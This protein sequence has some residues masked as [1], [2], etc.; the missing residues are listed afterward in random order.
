MLTG[1]AGKSG[2]LYLV[3]TPIGNLEDLTFRALRVLKEADVIAAE[4]TRETHKL[5]AHYDIHKP[6]LSY[7]EQN[8]SIAGPRILALLGEGKTVALV[9]DAGM[10]GISDPGTDLVDRCLDAGIRVVPVPGPSAVTAAVAC[11]GLRGNGFR[12]AGFL[13]RASSRRRSELAE[14]ARSNWITVYFEAPHRILKTLSDLSEVAGDSRIAVAREITKIHEEILRG[15]ARE[16]AEKLGTNP[17]GEYVILIEGRAE[18][19]R[20]ESDLEGSVS[21][22]HLLWRQ[23]MPMAE[24]V[25]S[26]AKSKGV[27]RKELYLRAVRRGFDKDP[28]HQR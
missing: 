19:Y 13:P 6:I 5:C 10:P 17:R 26:V 24:A 23:G 12:F 14:A 25:K 2:I 21:E 11:S 22:V 28:E 20:T 18:G 4:D 27:D 15:T 1:E 9:S 3:A 8:K 16:I 7:R